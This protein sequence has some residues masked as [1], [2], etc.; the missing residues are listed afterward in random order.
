[1]SVWEPRQVSGV[2]GLTVSHTS[3][4]ILR[5]RL[6]RIALTIR[7][8]LSH[9][10]RNVVLVLTMAGTRL[11]VDEIPSRTEVEAEPSDITLPARYPLPDG[12]AQVDATISY[13]VGGTKRHQ[14]L[15]LAVRVHEIFKTELDDLS[16][17]F[18]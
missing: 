8:P 12:V 18:E 1:M 13:E 6:Q 17:M 14:V 15:K 3:D 9:V 2:T 16:T 4:P 5:G 7:N 10:V 11:E